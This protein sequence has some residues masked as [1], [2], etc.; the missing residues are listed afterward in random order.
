MEKQIAK[1]ALMLLGALI[2][3]HIDNGV[4]TPP[5][6]QA[7]G[8]AVEM[9]EHLEDEQELVNEL[10]FTQIQCGEAVDELEAKLEELK[11]AIADL[12]S[13]ME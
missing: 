6:Y 1:H 5:M 3:T 13:S 8:I 9:A 4:A 12:R 11:I 2:E 7:L 10:K